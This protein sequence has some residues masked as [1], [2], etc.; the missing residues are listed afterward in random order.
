M[1]SSW[2]KKLEGKTLEV[3]KIASKG[4]RAPQWFITYMNNFKIE[5]DD[6]LNCRFKEFA[7]VN[8][9]KLPKNW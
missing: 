8:N 2:N 4:P 9:L 6:M 1:K 7:K 3:E 5:L